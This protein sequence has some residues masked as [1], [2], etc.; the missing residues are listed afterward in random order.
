MKKVLLRIGQFVYFSSAF[1]VFCQLNAHAYIDP[2]AVTYMIQAIAAVVIAVGVLFT[3]F[4]HKI[5]GFFKKNGKTEEKREIHFTEDEESQD[6]SSE[7]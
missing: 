1:F 7:E 5:I 3:V 2:S 4:R 6:T